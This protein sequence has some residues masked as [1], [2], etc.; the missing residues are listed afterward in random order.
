MR[1][2]RGLVEEQVLDDHAFHRRKAARDVLRVGV[3][4]GDVLALQIE[5][6][7][8][9][10]DRL[11]HHVG[12]AQA[13]L[14]A[15]LD[16]PELLEDFARRVVGDVAIA[17]E[18]VRERAHVA[19]ALH[20]VLPAQRVHANALAADVAGRHREIGDRHHRGRALRML[21]DAEAV[22][23]RRVS[24]RRIKPRRLAQLLRIDARLRGDR[25]R[26]MTFVGDEARPGLEIGA[27][28][29]AP[30]TKASSTRPSVTMT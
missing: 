6:L 23:D 8:G 28:R 10:V 21:G 22:I 30:R 27:D 25:L 16:A 17:R 11:V 19:G 29:N 18:L 20:V 3:G 1:V 9:A 26:R 2:A 12:D 14:A 5:A 24:A 7:E 13:R 4:L 15:E